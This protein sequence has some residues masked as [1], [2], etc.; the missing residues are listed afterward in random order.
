MLLERTIAYS[1]TEGIIQKGLPQ[2]ILSPWIF[3]VA[4]TKINKKGYS[5][6]STISLKLYTLILEAMQE[7]VTSQTEL[8]NWLD[9]KFSPKNDL[10]GYS[11][12]NKGDSKGLTQDERQ[13]LKPSIVKFFQDQK[14]AEPVNEAEYRQMLDRAM[15]LSLKY[16]IRQRSSAL[17]GHIYEGEKDIC[18]LVSEFNHNSIQVLSGSRKNAVVPISE[19]KIE[20]LKMLMSPNNNTTPTPFPTL[21]NL[22][23]GGFQNEKLYVAVAQPGGGKSTFAAQCADYAALSG[24]PVIF[25][26][27]EMGKF[28]LFVYSIARHG[29]INSSKVESP[30]SE[31]AGNIEDK[32]S[33][34]V[35]NYF[36]NIGPR[37]FTVEG[38]HKTSPASIEV[39]I[40]AV[41][42]KL[43]MDE[44]DPLLVVIDYL[45]LLSTGNQ[46][47]DH[48]QNETMKISELAVTTKQMA[49]NSKV[50][51]LAISDITK[52]E[53]ESSWVNKELSMNSPRGS[54]RIAHAADCVMALYSEPAQ[55]QGGKAETDPWEVYI[56]KFKSDEDDTPFIRKLSDYRED[57]KLGGDGA[58]VFSRIEIIKNRGGQGKGNQLT[59]YHRAYHK[60]EPV[61]IEGQDKTE[62]RA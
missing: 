37:L 36:E 7:G 26:A 16:E 1:L 48:G 22:L 35:E 21:N 40:S 14:D 30:Y 17:S 59:M 9:T 52:K 51:V 11:E 33:G 53:Q 19:K 54:N 34:T 43:G 3:P 8:A 46:D 39:M 44:N 61:E 32:L 25:V 24:I 56:D 18:T 62:R 41:K 13:K 27:M 55:S 4:S 47:L 50:S 58:S 57:T 2:E 15:D 10:D 42:S 31:V 49:R 28:Q 29:E 23:G 38:D 12:D 5:A 20:L 6:A 60:F 45:Q